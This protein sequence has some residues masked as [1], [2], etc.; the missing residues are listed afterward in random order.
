[1]KT[2]FLFS[3]CAFAA[4]LAGCSSDDFLAEVQ[5][6]VTNTTMEEVVGADLASKGMVIV[7][8]ADTRVN[9]NGWESTDNIGMGWYDLM[10]TGIYNEQKVTNWS[11]LNPATT[12]LTDSKIYANDMFYVNNGNFETKANVYQGAHFLYFPYEYQ[13]QITTRTFN[14]NEKPQ[15]ESFQTE[16]LNKA[17]HLSA[18]D[19]IAADEAGE[20]GILRKEFV[21][22][23]VVNAIKVVAAPQDEIS[24]NATMK[25]YAIRKM[26]IRSSTNTFRVF[27]GVLKPYKLQKAVYDVTGVLDREATSEVM[28][29]GANLNAAFTNTAYVKTLTTTINSA[30]LNLGETKELRAFTLPT[31]ASVSTSVKTTIEVYVGRQ[32]NGKDYDLGYFTVDESTGEMAKLN[33]ALTTGVN[34]NAELTLKDILYANG[35]WQ[36]LNLN[37]NLLASAFTPLTGDIKSVDQWNDLADLYDALVEILGADNVAVPTFTLGADLTFEDA[38]KTPKNIDVKFA[39]GTNKLIVKGEVE[40]PANLTAATSDANVEVQAEATLAVKTVLDAAIVNK[41]IIKAGPES[42]I[43][44][45]ASKKLNNEEGRVIVEYGAYVYPTV[46]KEGVVAYEVTNSDASNIGKINTLIANNGN[47]EYASVNTLIVSTT[48]DLNATASSSNDDR[49]NP[50]HGSTLNSLEDI[51]IELAN[52]TVKWTAGTNTTVKS[53]Q[54]IEGENTIYDINLAENVTIDEGA[55][56]SVDGKA[57]VNGVKKTFAMD[58]DIINAGTLIAETNI[59]CTNVDNAKGY[60]KTGAYGIIY[61]ETYTQ[62]GVVEGHVNKKPTDPQPDVDALANAVV[63]AITVIR[64]YPNLNLT[65]Y[66]KVVNNIQTFANKEQLDAMNALN[67]WSKALGYA[68]VEKTAITEVDLKFFERASGKSLGLTD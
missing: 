26:N 12:A 41:G 63:E 21:L 8:G 3:A 54:A 42:S 55:T 46:R 48:L 5:D 13:S 65:T 25:E 10:G 18:Q 68:E 30:D 33:A 19:F 9:S 62:G 15:T 37:V 27:T 60:I 14:V 28:R 49:Y 2:K 56:L 51:D 35:Q 34:G 64:D 43:S 36:P 53:V 11:R 57:D 59:T 38:I 50:S 45:Q 20:D 31:N 47:Q 7:L 24:A 58:G 52:G 16:M 32:A 6:P 39:T 67:A 17:L 66:A 22:A 44:T 1:M 4:F 40:W 61:S 23:P 29:K